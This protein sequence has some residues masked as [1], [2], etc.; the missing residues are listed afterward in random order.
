MQKKK[1]IRRCINYSVSYQGH[2]IQEKLLYSSN[3]FCYKQTKLL[4]KTSL[5]DEA[6]RAQSA[7]HH[8]PTPRISFRSQC[9]SFLGTLVNKLRDVLPSGLN[10]FSAEIQINPAL[11]AAAANNSIMFIIFT[12]PI[13]ESGQA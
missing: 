7:Q 9:S 8:L 11:P 1:Q 10:A 12:Y 13:Y 2:I 5:L 4:Q 3:Y 6:F